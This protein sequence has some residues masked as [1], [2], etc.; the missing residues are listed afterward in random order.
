MEN[1]IN[2]LRVSNSSKKKCREFFGYK[3]IGK[4]INFA[5]YLLENLET[6]AV[7]SEFI[8]D[9]DDKQLYNVL[10]YLIKAN[11]SGKYDEDLEGFD[12]IKIK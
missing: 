11:S 8:Y 1:N 5:R 10:L 6:G 9:Y 4:S 2:T 12:Y 7:I 3:G